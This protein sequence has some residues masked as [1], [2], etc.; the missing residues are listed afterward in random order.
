[1]SRTI[2]YFDCPEIDSHVHD[3]LSKLD[4]ELICVGESLSPAN[5]AL[6]KDAEIITM[7]VISTASAEVITA[8]PNLKHIACR[9]TGYDN[10]DLTAARERGISVSNVPSYGEATVAEYAFM[11]I[12]AL[13]RKLLPTLDA[14]D[15]GTIDPSTITG[16]DLQGK[17]IGIAGM[18]RIGSHIARIAKAFGMKVIAFD[19]YPK[20][21][22]AASVGF[23]YVELNE[24]LANSDIVSLHMPGTPANAH[25]IDARSLAVMK[26]TAILVNT[27]RGILVDTDALV[28]ALTNQ[29]LGGA[30]LDVVEGEKFL[31]LDE[32][33]FLLSRHSLKEDMKR[34]LAIEVLAKMPNVIVTSHNAY[35]SYEALARIEAT[36]V[37]NI[38]AFLR[39]EPSNIV[40]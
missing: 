16:T 10:I 13:S 38:A 14:I 35:N 9:S 7:H 34:A 4:Y 23:G 15:G 25:V 27:A 19:L 12:L 29:R 32:E 5:V 24:L 6:A 37:E 26:P 8:M 3:E 36:T 18:G 33:R 40:S 1:M 21:E 39:H 20:P 11:L 22:L 2:V 28:E 30:G 17:T 31:E